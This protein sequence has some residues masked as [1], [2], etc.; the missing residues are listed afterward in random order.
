MFKLKLANKDM[1]LILDMAKAL[2][3]PIEISKGVLDWYERGE[4]AGYG[5]LDWGA[6]LFQPGAEIQV[7]SARRQSAAR[8]T[9]ARESDFAKRH[10][11]ARHSDGTES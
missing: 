6:I 2:G 5:E 7:K 1:C 9:R 11:F 3:T 4:K 8:R 10:P